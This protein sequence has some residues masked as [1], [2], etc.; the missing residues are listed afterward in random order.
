MTKR[1]IIQSQAQLDIEEATFWYEIERPGLGSL[2]LDGLD[3]LLERIASSPRQFPE[4]DEGVRLRSKWR[5]NR[6]WRA[7]RARS[8]SGTLDLI[9]LIGEH[10]RLTGKP[11]WVHF[12]KVF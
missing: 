5:A 11:T 7:G 4:I 8:S 1:L 9:E 3:H 12:Q 2:F 10:Q 6:R